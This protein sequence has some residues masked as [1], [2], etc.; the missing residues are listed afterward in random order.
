MKATQTIS[1][2]LALASL[3]REHLAFLPT[4]LEHLPRLSERLGI[5]LLMKRDDQTGLALG[6]NKVRKLE[7]LLG[8]ALALGADVVITTGGTQSNHARIT[9][10]SCRRV[11]LDCCL[12]L[13]RGRHP[14]NGNL[15]LD[16][17]FGAEVEIIDDPDPVVAATRMHEVAEELRDNGRKPYVIPRGGSLPQGAVGYA[18][19]VAELNDQLQAG[20]IKPDDV[21]LATGS[22][23][24]HSGVMAGRAALGVTWKVQGVSVSRPREQQEQKVWE[25]SNQLLEWLKLDARVDRND[26]HVDDRFVGEGYGVP[27]AMTWGAIKALALEE[28]IV[29]DPVYTGKAMSGLIAAVN[30]GTVPYGAR[31]IFIHTGG[32]PALFGYAQELEEAH[33]DNGL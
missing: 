6:G 24:T 26:V 7:F 21:Y 9:A 3:P 22:C 13:D 12:V 29:L 2:T 4:P 32:A 19:M 31:V 5:E 23:G 33:G 17:L 16:H 20:G 14:E 8:D 28:A 15:L 25:L 1:L 10:A 27:T 18:A 11:G 30:E